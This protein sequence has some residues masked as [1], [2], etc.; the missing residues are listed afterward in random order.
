MPENWLER[1]DTR[2]GYVLRSRY[3]ESEITEG[4]AGGNIKSMFRLMEAM[5]AVQF[6]QAFRLK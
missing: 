6:L 3:H 5:E 4:R 1:G 2:I